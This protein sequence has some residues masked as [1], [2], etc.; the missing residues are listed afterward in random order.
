MIRMEADVA[1]KAAVI[2]AVRP[3]A[4]NYLAIYEIYLFG[5]MAEGTYDA[6]SDIDLAIVIDRSLSFGMNEQFRFCERIRRRTGR[7]VNLVFPTKCKDEGLLAA[8]ERSKELIYERT[9]L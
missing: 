2:E 4:T 6:G 7:S 3:I 8:I 1:D 9:V 5:P